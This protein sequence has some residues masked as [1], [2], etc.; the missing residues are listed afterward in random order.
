MT[1]IALKP[2]PYKL[3]EDRINKEGYDYNRHGVR[4]PAGTTIEDVTHYAFWQHA[5]TKADGRGLRIHDLLTVI[6][7]DL[8]FRAE[9]TVLAVEPR[10]GAKVKILNYWDLSD[11]KEKSLPSLVNDFEV[12]WRAAAKWSIV[13]KADGVVIRDKI[14]SQDEARKELAS[15]MQALGS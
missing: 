5:T 10:V 6:C 12:K 13:R 3:T 7:D 11:E 2:R 14:E 9:L 1:A 15:Y 4:V 8:A